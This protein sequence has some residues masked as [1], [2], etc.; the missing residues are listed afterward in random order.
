MYEAVRGAATGAKM[1]RHPGRPAK[2]IP[3]GILVVCDYRGM[4]RTTSRFRA[5]P[6]LVDLGAVSEER[7][8]L[9]ATSFS[10]RDFCEIDEV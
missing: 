2:E 10:V 4:C 8:G 1:R 5:A 7:T 6:M 9:V 3:I